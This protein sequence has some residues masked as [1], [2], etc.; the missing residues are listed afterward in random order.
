MSGK[1]T[2]LDSSDPDSCAAVQITEVLIS[3]GSGDVD[4]AMS[5]SPI[6]CPNHVALVASGAV[7]RCDGCLNVTR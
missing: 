3:E 5:L 4:S 1:F 7:A 6:T 2:L